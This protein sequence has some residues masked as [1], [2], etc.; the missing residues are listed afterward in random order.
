MRVAIP[1]FNGR[2]APHFDFATQLLV[3]TIDDRK[4]EEEEELSLIN[5]NPIRRINLLDELGVSVLICGGISCFSER[6]LASHGIDVI[7]MVQ[8]KITEVIGFFINRKMDSVI[9]PTGKKT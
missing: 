3:V 2:V 7:H 1:A 6:L 5:L 9:L 4:V 8:G